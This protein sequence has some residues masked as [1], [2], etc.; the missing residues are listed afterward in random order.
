MIYFLD[1]VCH[2]QKIESFNLL[3]KDCR[4]RGTLA[5]ELYDPQPYMMEISQCF[6]IMVIYGNIW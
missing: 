4:P 2:F 6:Y 3:W 5:K 1:L